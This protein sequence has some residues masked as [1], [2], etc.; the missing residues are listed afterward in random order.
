MTTLPTCYCGKPYRTCDHAA[1]DDSTDMAHFEDRN[2][3]PEEGK[4]WNQPN[5]AWEIRVLMGLWCRS[6]APYE[7]ATADWTSA[8]DLVRPVRKVDGRWVGAAWSEVGR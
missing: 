2:P 5:Q 8:G 6:F 4:A 7:G 1:P 3:T